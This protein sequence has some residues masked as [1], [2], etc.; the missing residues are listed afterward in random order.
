MKHLERERVRQEAAEA[1]TALTLNEL[2]KVRAH[3]LDVLEGAP[4]DDV[5]QIIQARGEVV[6]DEI[7]RRETGKEPLGQRFWRR[8]DRASVILDP[9]RRCLRE[10]MST[11]NQG[12]R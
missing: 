8:L 3:F 10:L 6:H 9:S 1:V 5:A 7:V 12:E 4:P 11:P 2:R